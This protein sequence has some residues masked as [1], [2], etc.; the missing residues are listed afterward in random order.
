MFRSV[1][2]IVWLLSR[3]CFQLL[4]EGGT[5]PVSAPDDISQWYNCSSRLVA[6]RYPEDI[7]DTSVQPLYDALVSYNTTTGTG[8]GKMHGSNGVTGG[9][10]KLWTDSFIIGTI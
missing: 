8:N 5:G 7:T 3:L 6:S 9:G 1:S 2:L 10:Y 4:V